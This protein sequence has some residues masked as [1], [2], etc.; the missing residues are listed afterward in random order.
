M[1]KIEFGG[2]LSCTRELEGSEPIACN[3][4]SIL[5]AIPLDMPFS[6]LSM[7]GLGE[8]E[9]EMS[10]TCRFCRLLFTGLYD[11]LISM[12]TE[13]AGSFGVASIFGGVDMEVIG[14]QGAGSACGM[15]ME[16]DAK[17]VCCFKSFGLLD[18]CRFLSGSSTSIMYAKDAARM[19][20]TFFVWF[21]YVRF[22]R[23]IS[24]RGNSIS[25]CLRNA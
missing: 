18:S 2:I 10:D 16:D 20:R 22:V 24:V 21:F 14:T 23:S 3:F 9:R 13:L 8:R 12:L 1:D 4:A 6:S 17:M 19:K 15:E 5:S 25:T 7:L 11:A